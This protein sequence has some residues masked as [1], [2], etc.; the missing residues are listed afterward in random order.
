MLDNSRLSCEEMFVIA[1]IESISNLLKVATRLTDMRF[2]AISHMT[3]THWT[4]CAVHDELDFGIAVGDAFEI[5]RM[6]CGELRVNPHP[7]IVGDVRSDS[8]YFDHNIPKLY[9]IE[10]FVSIP[11]VFLDGSVFGSLCMLD[12]APKKID[13]PRV[14]DVLKATVK[15]FSIALELRQKSACIASSSGTVYLKVN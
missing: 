11:I 8:N 15:L 2:G 13:C 14:I 9:G 12:Y 5:E 3:D 7:I 6:L 4:A 10:S 1:E